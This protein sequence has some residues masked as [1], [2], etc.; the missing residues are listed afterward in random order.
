M[1]L[2]SIT[3]DIFFLLVAFMAGVAMATQGSMNSALSKAI[4][5]SEATFVV[6]FSA[7][8]VIL[9]I[10][11][12]GISHGNWGNYSQVPWYYYLGGFI[13]VLITYGVVVSIPK[14]G[15]AVATTAIIVG[16]VLTA[17]LVDHFGFFGLEKIPFTWLKF[18]GLVFLSIG[19]K[20][21]LN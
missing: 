20:L 10:L 8:V 5:L 11:I 13:G 19:A 12:L 7:T 2:L 1:I 4:G 21:L 16:Q 15:V 18:L 17:C 3:K 14:L 9:I 6:H